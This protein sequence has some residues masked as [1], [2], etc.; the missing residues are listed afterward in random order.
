MKKMILLPGA[1]LGF[2]LRSLSQIQGD[3][4]DGKEKGIPNAMIIAMDSAGKSAD[5]VRSDTRG[6]YSFN[7]LKPGS[8]RIEVRAAGYQTAVIKDILVKKEDIGLVDDDLYAGQRIDV[9]LTAA[10][11]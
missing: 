3:V 11:K 8:Y 5:T 6:F 4:L 1:V 10:R 9:S 2:T 7:N